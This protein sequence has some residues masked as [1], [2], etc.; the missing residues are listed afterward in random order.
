[1]SAVPIPPRIV[2]DHTA[3][4]PAPP[5]YPVSEQEYYHWSARHGYVR[6]E[7]ICDRRKLGIVAMDTWTKFQIPRPQVRGPDVA[8]VR[9]GREHIVN[10]DKLLEPPDLAWWPIGTSV[11]P[12]SGAS[13]EKMCSRRWPS[14]KNHD[15]T[16]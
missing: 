3:R 11:R 6:A 10:Q 13:R 14:S 9:A 8:F 5:P 1:M 4:Y 2:A 12:G 16:G 7:W 15:A